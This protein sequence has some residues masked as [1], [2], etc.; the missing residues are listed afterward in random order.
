M[1]RRLFKPI[2][3]LLLGAIINVTVAWG[4]ATILRPRPLTHDNLS[5]AECIPLRNYLKTGGMG[6]SPVPTSPRTNVAL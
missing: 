3:F 2:V 6:V 5:R 4:C 1:K